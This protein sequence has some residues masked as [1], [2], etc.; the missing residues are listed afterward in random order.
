[1]SVKFNENLNHM[2]IIED[3]LS[4]DEDLKEE[5]SDLV[6]DKNEVIVQRRPISSYSATKISYD[7]ILKS[8]NMCVKDGKLEMIQPIPQDKN[9]A[10]QIPYENNPPQN[11]YI[12]NKNQTQQIQ[13]SP[14][15]RKRFL[16][17]RYIEIENQKRRIRQIKSTKLMFSNNNPTI[18][19]RHS[20]YGSNRLFRFVGK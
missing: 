4:D 13:L 7:D 15:E 12:H 16:I 19:A 6:K 11:N 17:K 8:M 14:E 20:P 2:V 3:V 9:Y 5:F 18:S 10:P 1:M